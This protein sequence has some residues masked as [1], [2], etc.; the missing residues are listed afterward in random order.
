MNMLKQL[1][2]AINYIE[3]K[4]CC[5]ELNLDEAAKIA[6]VTSDSFLR[7]FSYMT[8]MTLNEYVRRRRLSLA[9]NDLQQSNEKIINIALKYGYDSTDAFSRAFKKQHGITPSAYRRFGGSAKVYP[10]ASFHI[11]IKGASEMDFR[12]IDVKETVVYGVAKEYD[13]QK[14]STREALRHSMWDE[15]CESVPEKISNG[16]WNQ[17]QN[18][19]FDGVWYGIWQNGKY[20]IAR[21]K[22]NT[23]SDNLEEAIIT[24]GK[25]A[26]FTTN[27]G[28]R[29]W[30][31]LPKLF[32]LI[33]NSWL[34]S[35]EYEL[36][37]SDIVEIYHLWTDYEMR[38]K[39]RY[40]EVWIPIEDKE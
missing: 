7:F 12:I 36:R 23:N 17:P 31:E 3:G 1:N 28:G 21:E 37:N 35:S 13:T 2:L 5:N 27:R 32:E 15:N 33:F 9:V 39:N 34:P 10:P 40:Y 30:E 29:A 19:V 24:K 16:K 26:A 4:L 11:I 6:C 22:E 18:K 38:K 20:M 25:Y 14:Y 8:G